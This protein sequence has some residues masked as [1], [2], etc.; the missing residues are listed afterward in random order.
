MQEE[1][2]T[3]V[4]LKEEY[5]SLLLKILYDKQVLQVFD[6]A[7]KEFTISDE[8]FKEIKQ[9]A[10][11]LVK[12]KLADY[13]DEERTTLTITN[14]GRYWILKGGYEV[15]LREAHSTKDHAA[16]E[17]HHSKEELLEAR[18]KLTHFRLIGFWL[19]LIISLAGFIL[20]L[21]NLYMFLTQ[22]K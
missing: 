7:A 22:K 3:S 4:L 13:A 11:L 21:L 18:L 5:A 16:M 9:V 17:K 12:E 20:S 1:N 6:Y 15:F 19:T 8:R 14:F 2:N 10:D